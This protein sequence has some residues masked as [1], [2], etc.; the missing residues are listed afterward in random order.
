MEFLILLAFSL[1]IL[2]YYIGVLIYTIPVPWWGLKRWAPTLIYDSLASIILLF[3]YTAI[4]SFTSYLASI[5]NANWDTLVNWIIARISVLSTV[6]LALSSLVVIGS[7]ILV[8]TVLSALIGPLLSTI[9]YIMLTLQIILTLTLVVKQYYTKLLILGI[10]LYSVPFRLAR[11]VGSG[12]IAFTIVFSIG[13]PLLPNFIDYVISDSKVL[14]EVEKL[15]PGITREDLEKYGIIFAYGDVVDYCGK[16]VPKALLKAVVNGKTLAAY[17]T[18]NSGRF[19]AGRPDRGLP[20]VKFK[21]IVEYVGYKLKTK[22]SEIGEEDYTFNPFGE[23]TA[24]YYIKITVENIYLIDKFSFIILDNITIR[25]LTANNTHLKVVVESRS[26]NVMRVV[27]NVNY[28]VTRVIVNGVTV[29]TTYTLNEWFNTPIAYTY[30]IPLSKGLNNV[31][32][33]YSVSNKPIQV[34]IRE[35][36][37]VGSVLEKYRN[38]SVETVTSILGKLVFSWIILPTMYLIMLSSISYSLAYVIGGVRP[39]L[40]VRERW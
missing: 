17:V 25:S 39:R 36:K 28:N 21:A 32:I 16:P 26:K 38:V 20:R 37:Y 23:P 7:K 22:P 18:G 19:V 6:S 15:N 34:E 31:T 10:V 40:P 11:S 1:S 4:T 29:N 33:V 24:E 2:T 9:F 5:F 35:L 14:S 13:L 27:L 8:P 30:H 12:I 3:S